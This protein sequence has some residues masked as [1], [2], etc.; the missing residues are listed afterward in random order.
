[1]ND[2]GNSNDLSDTVYRQLIRNTATLTW[3]GPAGHSG[4][5]VAFSGA[6]PHPLTST[7]D[8]PIAT[9]QPTTT[10]P[11]TEMRRLPVD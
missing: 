1:M 10:R 3:A 11:D 7:S 6:D 4:A 9:I 5:T 2:S 8:Q